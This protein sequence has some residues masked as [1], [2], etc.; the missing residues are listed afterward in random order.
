MIATLLVAALAAAAAPEFDVEA[1]VRARAERTLEDAGIVG[2]VVGTLAHG[3]A[4]TQG[5]GRLA[6]DVE[7]TP[8]GETL[9]E[10]GSITK[11]FTGLL[12]ALAVERGE[13][14]LDT[15]IAELLPEP[16]VAP[17]FGD[18]PIRLEHLVTHTSG[19]PRMPPD[20]RPK[21]PRNPF[22]DYEAADLYASLSRTELAQAPGARYAYSNYG[23]GLL[24]HLLE[25]AGGASYEELVL[26][27][28]CEPLGLRDT[29]ATLAEA[30]RAR[31]APGHAANGS[32]R[33]GWTF[34]ALAGAGALRSSAADMLRFARANLQPDAT[35]I[36]A[37][38]RASRRRLFAL[39][40][41]GGVA[42]GWHVEADGTVWHN[43][44]TGGY[45]SIL[46]F[47]EADAV[48]VVV[49]ANTMTDRV[50]RLGREV[51]TLLRRAQRTTIE[52]TAKELKR[53]AGTYAFEDPKAAPGADQPLRIDV[54]GAGLKLL[55]PGR[56]PLAV[57][58]SSPTLFFA[59][60]AEVE[61]EFERAGDATIDGLTL[62]W[63]GRALRA[64][65]EP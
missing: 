9:F 16:D 19:L 3:E 10:I 61:V 42:M 14:Q 13:V 47:D 60:G 57:L 43:G 12:L 64:R 58:P 62:N 54:E 50:D 34:S 40:G 55:L 51:L 6:A 46:L 2:L 28:I 45:R 30:A 53:Y 32:P 4:R 48:A 44:G 39:P 59:R 15:E 41:G 17:A 31:L 7:A 37:A 35:P 1:E 24:G 29:R 18:A 38:L 25:R 20:F 65:R 5:F 26:K 8:D 56:E 23:A 52:L 33:A 21:D 36:G 27:R 22:D 11:T 49:L 63:K